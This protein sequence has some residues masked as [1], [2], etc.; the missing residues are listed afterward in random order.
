MKRTARFFAFLIAAAILLAGAVPAFAYNGEVVYDGNARDFVFAPGSEYSPTDLFPDLKDVMPGDS[1][2]QKITVRNTADKSVRVKIYLRSLGAQEGTDVFLS[3]L[4]LKVVDSSNKEMFNA[5]A[6]Q[7]DGLTDW[8]LLGTLESGGQTDLT[9]QLDVPTTIGNEFSGAI[10]YIDWE[11]KV[12]EI[13]VEPEEP[14]TGDITNV[15]PW[16]A[17]GAAVV[18]ALVLLVVFRRKK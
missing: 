12:E 4:S 13:P 2:T 6:D 15:W 5:P 8:V 17:A 18:V 9:V 10:G 11:F 14:P 16:I 1:I 3:Q 7:T